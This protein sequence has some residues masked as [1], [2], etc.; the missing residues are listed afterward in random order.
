MRPI[1][2]GLTASPLPAP[3]GRAGERL[4][5]VDG[6]ALG[7]VDGGGVGHL[8]V[9][10]H[11][12]GRQVLQPAAVRL[13]VAADAEGPVGADLSPGSGGGAHDV[14]VRIWLSQMT[15]HTAKAPLR[16]RRGR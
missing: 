12:A 2:A 3:F 11:I 16:G 15:N 9:L 10:G 4:G 1:G 7:A 8:H 5:R 13:V 14:V 6:A